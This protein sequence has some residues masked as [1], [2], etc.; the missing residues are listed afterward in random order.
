VTGF[1]GGVNWALLVAR[2]CH[3]YPNANPN[4]L[5]SRFF[6]V[7]TQW[8]WPNPVMLCS[9]EEDDLGF[10]VWD[11]RKNPRDCTHHMSIITAAY[12]CMNSSY[13]VSTRTRRV[14][15]E[16]FHNGNK[17]CEVDIVAADSDDLHS[18]KGWVESRLRQ[19]TLMVLGNQMVNN[20]V[21]M[22]CASCET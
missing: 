10:P 21:F 8:C 22:Q 15:M 12:P 20:V 19:L 18:W 13:N 7:Y 6:R 11:P 3:L 2:V 4:K 9:I 1:L 17:I 16:Q 5:V 14:M